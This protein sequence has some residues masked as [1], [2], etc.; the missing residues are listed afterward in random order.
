MTHLSLTIRRL[1]LAAVRV[2]LPRA[3]IA[4]KGSRDFVVQP[5]YRGFKVQLFQSTVEVFPIS[6]GDRLERETE[7]R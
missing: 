4:V 5:I 3:H 7:V 2:L 1:R 6:Y